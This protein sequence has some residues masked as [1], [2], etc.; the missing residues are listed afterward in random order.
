MSNSLSREQASCQFVTRQPAL[1]AR[2]LDKAAE[3]LHECARDI[4]ARS[5][6]IGIS[7]NAGMGD[8]FTAGELKG[9]HRCLNRAVE[10]VGAVRGPAQPRSACPL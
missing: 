10:G 2:D 4:E 8:L 9:L 1:I 6:M 5:R 7:P 3:R